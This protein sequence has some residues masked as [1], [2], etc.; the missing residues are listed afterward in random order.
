MTL[1]LMLA[2]PTSPNIFYEKFKWISK[3]AEFKAYFGKA[4]KVVKSF[5][6]LTFHCEQKLVVSYS[7]FASFL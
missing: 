4:E 7:T 2:K 3:I 5:R 6:A 1:A